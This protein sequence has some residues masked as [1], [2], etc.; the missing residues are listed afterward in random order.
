MRDWGF[1]VDAAN[2][3]MQG[4]TRAATERPDV[5]VTDLRMPQGTG[6]Y[7]VQRLRDDH[8]TCDIPV[9]VL[10]GCRDADLE[11]QMRGLNVRAFFTKPASLEAL[12]SA[13]CNVLP[14]D[15]AIPTHD[16]LAAAVA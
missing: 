11:M 2:Y 15:L 8:R 7:V 12:R 5:I 16:D 1:D 10:T 14:G 9:I 4:F 3:G 13:I 6:D